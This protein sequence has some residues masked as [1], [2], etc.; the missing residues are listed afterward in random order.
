MARGR[1]SNSTQSNV[2]TPGDPD[3]VAMDKALNEIAKT[4]RKSV[5]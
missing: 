2:T 5:V 1:Q 4:D 3:S